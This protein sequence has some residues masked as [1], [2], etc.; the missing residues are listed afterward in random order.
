MQ[1][2]IICKIEGCDGKHKG[3]GYC[4]KHY[5]RFK[6]NG[7]PYVLLSKKNKFDDKCTHPG[8]DSHFLARGL[9]NKHYQRLKVHGD[10]NHYYFREFCCIDNCGKKHFAHGLCS[11]HDRRRRIYGDPL[12]VKVKRHYL[13]LLEYYEDN[14]NKSSENGCWEWTAGTRR[15]YGWLC[16]KNV[17]VSA[18]RFAYEHFIG[19]IPDNMFCCHHCDNKLCCNP[20]HLFIGT[21]SDNMQDMLTKNRGR[22]K[23]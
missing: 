2:K 17:A 11:A 5:Q 7:D 19:K 12:H 22:W 8:C 21:H 1:E 15:G 3:H 20:D 13:T 16:V 6:K 10:P 9:C 14:I 18:H 23:K 4:N